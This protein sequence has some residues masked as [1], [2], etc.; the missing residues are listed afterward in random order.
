MTE[1]HIAHRNMLPHD[2]P[3]VRRLLQHETELMSYQQFGAGPS[4]DAGP[5]SHITG[6][7]TYEE[8]NSIGIWDFD[9]KEEEEEEEEEEEQWEKDWESNSEQQQQMWR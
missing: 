7:T 2:D 3:Y 1:A 6:P 5:S 4:H 9:S 8:I